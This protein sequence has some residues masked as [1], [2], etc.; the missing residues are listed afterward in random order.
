LR[1]YLK[2]ICNIFVS[3]ELIVPIDVII[4]DTAYNFSPRWNYKRYGKR[5]FAYM[6]AISM[7]KRN[8]R[9]SRYLSWYILVRYLRFHL[10]LRKDKF[11]LFFF[12]FSV[13]FSSLPLSPSIY[14]PIY[15][16]LLLFVVRIEVRLAR[17]M[18]P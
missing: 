7:N 17:W 2:I 14:L 3:R 9:F 10:S 4:R 1:T 16:F 5:V 15:L 11:Y 12:L 8:E 18:H 6:K 13:F